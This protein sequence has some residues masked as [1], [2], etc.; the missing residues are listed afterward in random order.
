MWDDH[1]DQ[2]VSRLTRRDRDS[3]ADWFAVWIDSRGDKTA[4]YAFVVNVA[5]VQEDG[6]FY[7]DG[8]PTMDWDA[9][10][11]S[12]T[13][14]D[15][16]GWTAEIRIPLSVFR[17]SALDVQ[18][19]GFNAGRYIS[20]NKENDAWSFWASTL[21]GF[22]NRFGHL[23]GLTGLRPHRTWELR[24]FIVAQMSADT[25]SGGAFLGLSPG[26]RPMASVTAGAD[27]KLGLTSD[28]TL[29][30][31]VNPDFGQVEADQVVLNLSRFETFFPEKRPFFLEGV[32]LFQTP[33]QLFYSR[34][35][36]RP[37]S[38][39]SDGDT[40]VLDDSDLTVIHSPR[41]LPI[42][43]AL[44][45]TG[46]I[47]SHLQVAALE[48]V[49]GPEDLTATYDESGATRDYELSPARSF[50][51][52][53]AR[54][55]F[56]NAS[57]IG[58][59]ATAATRLGGNFQ[60]AALDHDDYAQGIDGVWV[61]D[62]D[63]VKLTAQAAMTQR[64]GGESFQDANG[65]PCPATNPVTGCLPVTRDDG[66]RLGPGTVGLGVNTQLQLTFAHAIGRLA[67]YGYTGGF[68]PNALGFVQPYNQ[69]E[70]RGFGGYQQTH[71][72]GPFRS[73][74]TI[75]GN[76]THVSF[77]GVAQDSIFFYVIE[78]TLRNF[79]YFNLELDAAPPWTYDIYETFDGARWEK[80][81]SYGGSFYL[82][83]DTRKAFDVA[84]GMHAFDNGDGHDVGAS[85]TIDFNM[86]SQLDLSLTPEIGLTD[87]TRFY[88][89]TN[90][91]GTACSVDD[92]MRHYRF[93]DLESGYMSFT[94]RGTWTFSP[95]VTFQA[96]AQLFMDRGQ[97]SD[98][99]DVD[100]MATERRPIIS[101]AS[102]QPSSF[103][104]DTDG[105]GVK[106]DDFQD[107]QLN[108]NLV[109]RWELTPG[110]TLLGV[111]TRAENAAF[112]LAGRPPRFGV[113]GLTSGP[114]EDVIL[115][116]LVYFLG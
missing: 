33:I 66:T 86:V 14:R 35:I 37:P 57:N 68:D 96:Y 82:K 55:D 78:G 63:H 101:R 52:L 61:I 71:P 30:G 21:P 27:F 75:L 32:D 47:S 81:S 88:S 73:W 79:W 26:V 11:T 106:D 4:A 53:R 72:D 19:W 111:F 110:T 39:F 104:G 43:A 9:V 49:T 95:N 7:N 108:L 2:I 113:A 62:P 93:A 31:T 25:D 70:F 48:A 38:G 1:A 13:S 36:G 92:I 115:W 42:Y 40:L 29:D 112:N 105:D 69:Q 10:W 80:T 45:V 116:K 16:Q 102:L 64:E 51:V 22:V 34:R 54:W 99:R 59:M 109:F 107:L 76:V 6:I 56:G 97:Y 74:D 103:N 91:E 5:G 98:Y 46:K 50:S 83:P 67:Y 12:A 8:D 89:C 60:L 18:S 85:I 58:V 23:D 65:L 100:I 87:A 20:R 44:K 3:E 84:G 90:P 94:L 24:P 41:A 77:D 15:D 17:F 28:L 114:T